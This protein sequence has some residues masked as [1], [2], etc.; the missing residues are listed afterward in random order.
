MRRMKRVANAIKFN[1]LAILVVAVYLC[2]ALQVSWVT[3][4]GWAFGLGLLALS[5]VITELCEHAALQ[6]PAH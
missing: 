6:D 3:L 2:F 4:Q 5:F 1:V